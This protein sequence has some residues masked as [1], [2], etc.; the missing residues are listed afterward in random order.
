MDIAVIYK[1]IILFLIQHCFHVHSSKSDWSTTEHVLQKN[2]IQ[3]HPVQN[4]KHFDDY[5]DL[6][7]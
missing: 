5:F 2:Y 6:I 3:E 4:N 7:T 1:Y